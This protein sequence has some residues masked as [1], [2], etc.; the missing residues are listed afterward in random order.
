MEIKIAHLYPR[1]LNIYGDRGNVIC[2][3]QRCQWRQIKVKVINISIGDAIKPKLYDLF[4]GGGGQDKQQLI[5]NKDL[6][7]KKSVL[8]HEADRGVPMLAV[9]GTYQLFTHFFKTNTGKKIP[10]I[11]I[12]DGFTVASNVRKMGN[13][14]IKL[15]P[16]VLAKIDQANST[17]LVGFENHWGN[18][19]I[20]P[21][22]KTKPLGTVLKGHG[23]NGQDK[24]EGAVYKN[25]FGCYLHGSLLPKNPH[26]LKQLPG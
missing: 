24:T 2:L 19:Y 13:I 5:V 10:G 6:Q 11:S 8:K 15:K 25:V 14:V 1:L 20:K 18:T 9:C 23:N 21:S 3:K 16:Q 26:D 12:F 4:F 22:S 7:T 17:K